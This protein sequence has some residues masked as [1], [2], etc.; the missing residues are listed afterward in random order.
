MNI[1]IN[2]TVSYSVANVK[3]NNIILSNTNNELSIIVPFSWT[4]SSDTDIRTGNNRYT[5]SQLISAFRAYGQDFAPILSSLSSL[6]PS[7]VA[8][9]C[10]IILDNA[11]MKAIQGYSQTS[12]TPKWITTTLSTSQLSTALVPTTL[13]QISSMITVFTMATT[14]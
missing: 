9:N 11:G 14:T 3:I 12:P 1:P 10:N 7:G 8:G 5:A 2:K 4:D 6:I 13:D